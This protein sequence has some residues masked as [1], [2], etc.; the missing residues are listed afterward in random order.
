MT[1]ALVPGSVRIDTLAHL[2]W[3]DLP[4]WLHASAKPGI[5]HAARIVAEASA[6][7]AAVYGVNTGFGKLASIKIAPKDTATLQR[8]LILSHCSGVGEADPARI[9][10]LM[11]TLKLISLGRGASGV[12]WEIICLIEDMLEKGVT[13]IVPAQGSV[14]ASGD[15][16]PLAHMAAVMIGEGEAEYQG[17]AHAGRR[18]A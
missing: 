6:G 18:G 9:A 8:N 3:N 7:G 15:L 4:S 16:A 10:R 12:R 17:Q 13:P 5:E 11:M 2:Y 1:V 14:G